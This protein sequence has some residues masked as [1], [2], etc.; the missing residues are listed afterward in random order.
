MK[1]K[2]KGFETSEGNL[3]DAGQVKLF[4]EGAI[5][6]L[7]GDGA[8]NILSIPLR[9]AVLAQKAVK[10]VSGCLGEMTGRNVGILVSDMERLAGLDE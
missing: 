1:F 7:G 3:W 8:W 5:D 10:V 2:I 9:R 4:V 6:E